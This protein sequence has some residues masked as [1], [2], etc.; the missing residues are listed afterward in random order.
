MTISFTLIL[1]VMI[2][3][4]D[5]KSSYSVGKKQKVLSQNKIASPQQFQQ[6]RNLKLTQTSIQSKWEKITKPSQRKTGEIHLETQETLNE[7]SSLKKDLRQQIGNLEHDRSAMLSDLAKILSQ[8]EPDQIAE[9]LSIF[10]DETTKFII[11]QY[12]AEF[13]KAIKTE[14]KKTLKL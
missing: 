9:E 8:L 1:G 7:F 12:E 3:F 11:S 2:V 13:Q 4:T 14:I 10:D 6:D 5:T